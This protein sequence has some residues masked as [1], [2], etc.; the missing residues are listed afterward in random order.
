[1]NITCYSINLTQDSDISSKKEYE[2]S[3][4]LYE[5]YDNI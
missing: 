1:M 5:E 4:Y 2:I 3:M